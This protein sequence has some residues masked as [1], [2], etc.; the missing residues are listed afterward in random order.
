[1]AQ[2]IWTDS[3]LHDLDD[4]GEYISKDSKKY[5]Q[6]TVDQLFHSPDILEDHPK[7]GKVV[8]EFE[9]DAIREIIRG[10]Y[11]IVYKLVD[12]EKIYILAVHHGARL[13][14]NIVHPLKPK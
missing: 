14:G 10:N 3:A 13:I 5:A 8:P 9:L 2:V 4:I 1:M 11:R 6:I 12:S 7:A